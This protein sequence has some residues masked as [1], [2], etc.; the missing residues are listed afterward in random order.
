ME[1]VR[2][3]S[4]SSQPRHANDVKRCAVWLANHL[5]RIGMD[6]VEIAPTPG[7]PIVYAK[8][9]AV[10]G[11]PT[12]LVYGHYD[13]VPPD[14][15]KQW[16][17]PPFEPTVRGQNLYGRGACDDKGQLFTHVKA[18]ESYL[19]SGAGLPVNVKCIFEGEEEIGSPNLAPFLAKNKSALRAN[20]AVISDTRMLGPNRPA[21]SYAQRGFLSLEWQIRGT[22]QDLHSGNF[23]GA[24]HNPLQALSEMIAA[25]H[26]AKGRI[27]IPGFYEDVRDWSEKERAEMAR[28][29]PADQQILDD[30]GA[31]AGWGE[32]GY[33][34][35]ERTTIR[36]AL[37]VNGISGGY[38]GT[39]GKAIIPAHASAKLSFRLVPDQSPK[40]VERLFRHHIARITPATV[41]S[42]VRTFA[43][44]NPVVVSRDHPAVRAAAFAYQKGFGAPAAL[45]RSGGSIPVVDLFQEILHVPTVLMGFG[46]PTDRIHAPNEK[47]HLPNFHRGIATAIWFLAAGAARLK[48]LRP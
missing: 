4:V 31:E 37:T 6:R 9:R 11:R 22:A 29:G 47:F 3:P 43:S 38:R 33:T 20:A 40:Q 45:I 36:P 2:F 24:I 34:L 16:R 18:L 46:L 48:G 30:A 27:T 1:F 35:Y 10:R 19:R 13:V 44:A 26:D 41:R 21:I 42:T 23:G 32:R 25:L 5:R 8:S 15:I 28:T 17:T 12:V 7:N 14:P 39:G